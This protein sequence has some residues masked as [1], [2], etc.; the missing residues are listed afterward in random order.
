MDSITSAALSVD[1]PLLRAAGEFL[2]NPL[3]FSALILAALLI[4]ESRM[5]KRKKA[6][7]SILLAVLCG[8]ALKFALAV[9]RPCAGESWCPSDFSFPSLH[10]TAAFSLMIGFLNKK[11][12]PFYL[13][14]AL[15]IGFT[16]MNIGVHVFADIAAALPIAIV[17]YYAI[18]LGEK[19]GKGD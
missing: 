11:S 17:A 18:D 12:F 4:G 6:L 5:E 2:D 3:V 19:N 10:A 9:E 8:Y 16:R 7:L 1:N 15:F 13:L 14:F